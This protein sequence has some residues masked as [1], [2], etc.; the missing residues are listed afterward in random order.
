MNK[1]KAYVFKNLR[2]PS[3]PRLI[4]AACFKR[5]V[6]IGVQIS[7][8]YERS[9]F[10]VTRVGSK[11]PEHANSLNSQQKIIYTFH[12]VLRLSIEIFAEVSHINTA[13]T[14]LWT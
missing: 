4:P 2:A 8:S 14:E 3:P 6:D 9:G 10:T 13:L 12:D 11:A 7:K 5:I 1:N